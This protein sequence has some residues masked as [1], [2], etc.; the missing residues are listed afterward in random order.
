MRR[1]FVLLIVLAATTLQAQR[2]TFDVATIKRNNSANEAAAVHGNGGRL[3]VVNNPLRNI[4]RNAWN[5]QSFQ[6]VGGPSWIDSERWNILAKAEGN[7]GMQMMLMVQNLLADRF[8]LVAHKETREM[9]IYAL[10]F[11]RADHSLGPKLHASAT[12]CQ[13]E[14]SAAIARTGRVPGGPNSPLL[15]GIRSIPGHFELN[16]AALGSFARTLAP[17][18][19]RSIVDKTGLTGVYDAELTWNDSEEGPSLF[20]AIQ[21]QLGLKLESQRGPVDVLVID[22]VEHPTED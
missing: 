11:A 19:G 22:S 2:P 10:T 18:A 5:L 16:A 7:P 8:R 1:F 21:E 9:P 3:E 14:V 15:C 4:I 20:T 17:L 13:K 6:I 12:D